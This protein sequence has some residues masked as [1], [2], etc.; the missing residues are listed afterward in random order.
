MQKSSLLHQNGRSLLPS[1]F[2]CSICGR[3]SPWRE[4]V[5]RAVLSPSRSASSGVDVAA[6]VGQ[7]PTRRLSNLDAP[8]DIH[9]VMGSDALHPTTTQSVQHHAKRLHVATN[10]V[11]SSQF[12][13]DAQCSAGHDY[14]TWLREDGVTAGQ[15]AT[16]PASVLDFRLHG[17][18]LQGHALDPILIDDGDGVA[19][20]PDTTDQEFVPLR[21]RVARRIESQ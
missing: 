19:P 1:V 2:V 8:V 18:S 20:A 16:G 12:G 5:G 13:L 21:D 15:C 4:F 17:R 3:M 11:G 7:Q 9:P 14:Q 6:G 10:A